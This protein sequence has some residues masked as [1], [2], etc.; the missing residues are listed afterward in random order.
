MSKTTKKLTTGQAATT[1]AQRVWHLDVPITYPVPPVGQQLT[2]TLV[3]PHPIAPAA[4]DNPDQIIACAGGVPVWVAEVTQ[5]G[6]PALLPMVLLNGN[7][8]SRA[9]THL[10]PAQVRIIDAPIHAFGQPEQA[11]LAQALA[12]VSDT[13]NNPGPG[14]LGA[15]TELEPPIA[16]VAS[17]L[18]APTLLKSARL[19]KGTLSAPTTAIAGRLCGPRPAEYCRCGF[20][21]AQ[22]YWAIE[23]PHNYCPPSPH[24]RLTVPVMT[25][26]HHRPMRTGDLLFAFARGKLVQIARTTGSGTPG[27][28]KVSIETSADR[29]QYR[30]YVTTAEVEILE[31]DLQTLY[32]DGDEF[33]LDE[34]DSYLNDLFPGPTDCA[35]GDARPFADWLGSCIAHTLGLQEV[36]A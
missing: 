24:A 8:P 19:P 17:A 9:D 3:T 26:G 31:L 25:I 11:S 32:D 10:I 7:A 14:I 5:A 12:A 6:A 1:P 21:H 34:L 2:L 20:D 22:P 35:F 33:V 13:S 29:K 36:A 27:E 15:A 23:V 4:D 30:G 18:L 16:R 28:L